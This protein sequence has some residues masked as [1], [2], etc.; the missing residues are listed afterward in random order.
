M[1]RSIYRS[2]AGRD[3]IR[4]WCE[5]RLEAA[6]TTGR[7]LDTSLGTSRVTVVG[8]GPDVVLLPGTNF[9]TA[10]SRDEVARFHGG[11]CQTISI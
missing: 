4:A 7:D 2:E 8:S 6:G 11:S 1:A 9:S 3:A 10:I 5:L